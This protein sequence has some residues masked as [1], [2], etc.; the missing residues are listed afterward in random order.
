MRTLS[1]LIAIASIGI[2]LTTCQNSSPQFSRNSSEQAPNSAALARNSPDEIH[3]EREKLLGVDVVAKQVVVKL[4]SCKVGDQKTI[5]DLK[6]LVESAL[7]DDLQVKVTQIGNFCWFLVESSKFSTASL[8]TNFQSKLTLSSPDNSINIVDAEPNFIISVDPELEEQ[9][10]VLTV[11]PLQNG[12]LWGLN[13]VDNPGIDI[14]A[15]EAWKISKGS[16]N[17]AVGI[18]D[19]GFNFEHPDLTQNV[20]SAPGDFEIKLGTETIRC[21]KGSHGYNALATQEVGKCIPNDSGPQKGHGTHISGIIGAA[22][23]NNFGVVGVNW[24]TQLIG[25]KFLGWSGGRATDAVKAIEF[26]IQL[27]K[28]F[29]TKAN[30][31]ILNVSWGYGSND[32]SPSETEML[33]EA[34]DRAR[35][36]QDFLI[37]A[38]AGQNALNNDITPHYPS[39]FVDLPNLISVTA[40]DRKGALAKIHASLANIGKTKVH[41][42]APAKGIYSTYTTDSN[43][44]CYARN[45]GTSMATPFVSG[46]AALILSTENCVGLKSEA[47]RRAILVG[48]DPTPSMAETSTGGRLNVFESIKRCR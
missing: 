29:G 44:H 38:S 34:L 48:T 17:I 15:L 32:V 26:A 28:L 30:I 3:F 7:Q 43:P 4:E 33:R 18:V 35:T 31:R 23:D 10:S 9:R 6:K 21:S 39:N 2:C 41:L 1:S 46:A 20:W 47:L 42:G 19:T 45:S 16:R 14:H 24:N 40:I 36:E 5:D 12:E 22:G 8:L 13:N 27:H 25:L 11:N 37:V